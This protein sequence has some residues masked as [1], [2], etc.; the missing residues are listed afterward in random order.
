MSSKA[1]HPVAALAAEVQRINDRNLDVR[2]PVSRAKD[3]ISDLSRTLNQML[4]RI[5][6]AFASVLAF[7]GNASHELRT[8][9]TLL[10]TEIEIA[11]LRPR[12]VEEY[13]ATLG[14]LHKEI[15][16]MTS[17]LENL[18][19]LARADAGAETIAFIPIRLSLLLRHVRESW[20]K[21]MNQ[22]ALNFRVEIPDDRVTV[23][24]DEISLLRLFSILLENARKFTTPGG[25]V[26]L[27]STVEESS[28]H[29]SLHDT[30]SGIAPEHMPHIFERFYR[31]APHSSGSGLGL[32]LAM[33][34]ANR[35]GTDLSVESTPGHGSCFSFQLQRADYATPK[36]HPFRLALSQDL[37]S[38]PR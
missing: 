2:L 25:S 27:S 30:G 1:L 6:R 16:G 24:A 23:W 28:I 34:I 35:H 15:L 20:Q 22:S 5:D 36:M 32:A 31:A 9:I 3:E 14:F 13:R 37:Q 29:F 18:L 17:L 12:K 7:T 8:P 19:S 11:L 33:W 10:R 4:E 26:T 38:S 21:A